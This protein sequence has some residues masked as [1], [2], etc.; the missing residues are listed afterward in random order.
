MLLSLATQELV[1]DQLPPD[2]ELRDLGE[3]CLKDL[4]RPEKVFQLVAPGL[5]SEFP[6]LRTLEARPNNLPL[7]PTP[8]VGRER[9]VSEIAERLRSEEVRLL[10]LTGPGG[11]GKTRLALQVGAD[12]LEEFEGGVF[13]VFL[14]TITDPKLVPSAIAGFLGIKESAGRSLEE[15]LEAYLREKELLLILDNLEQILEGTPLVGKLLG[16]CP[17]LKVLATSRI[18]LNVWC[19][20]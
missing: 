20:F 2:V 19:E 1:R 4:F 6:P 5:P 7:Q 14:A 9:E 16:G 17:R 12:L 13:F 8:L 3:R 15:N 10:T 18:P 11:I